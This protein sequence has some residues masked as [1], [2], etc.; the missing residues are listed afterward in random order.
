MA[1]GKAVV[2]TSVPLRV[3]PS[4]SCSPRRL[5]AEPLVKVVT[6]VGAEVGRARELGAVLTRRVGLARD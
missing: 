5:V 4:V 1:A 3:R 2:S 6:D